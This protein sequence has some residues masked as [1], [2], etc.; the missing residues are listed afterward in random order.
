[1]AGV[2]L[3]DFDITAENSEYLKNGMNKVLITG[4]IS[5]GRLVKASNHSNKYYEYSLIPL[6]INNSIEGIQCV[7][8]DTTKTQTDEHI[9]TELNRLD[10]FDLIGKMAAGVAHEIRNPIT[11][12]R[13]YLQRFLGNPAKCT[14]ESLKIL[15]TELD[16]VNS[17]VSEFLTLASNKVSLKAPCDLNGLLEEIHP[18]IYEDAAGRGIE[19]DLLF[20]SNLPVLCLDSKEIKQLILNLSRNSLDVMKAGGRLTI[21]TKKLPHAVGLSV[22]DTGN[23]IPEEVLLKMFDPFFTTKGSGTGLGLS[24]CMS[25][26]ARHKGAIEVRSEEG[27]GAEFIV[28]FPPVNCS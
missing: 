11:V 22:A 12:I 4:E 25:I 28:T 16:R 20:A 10:R 23:G 14:Q 13:G 26:V 21:Q 19:V 8:R 5:R 7:I 18:L 3:F 6:A 24:V 1:M 27:K 2:N 15:L 17:I 9:Q